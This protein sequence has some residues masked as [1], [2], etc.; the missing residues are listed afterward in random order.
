MLGATGD[1]VLRLPP[2]VDDSANGAVMRWQLPIH[3]PSA[4]ATSSR[5]IGTKLAG[6]LALLAGLLVVFSPCALH[7]TGV[8][9]PL[10]TGLGAKDV[11]S[12][13]GDGAFR[14][15]VVSLGL[16]FVSGFVILYTAFGVA[17][18]FA[19]RFF[20]DTSAL[21]PYL[22]PLRLLAGG[23]VIIMAL[24][25][26]GFFKLPYAIR[27]GVPKRL[28]SSGS[29]SRHVA[30]MLAGANVSAGCL[31]CVGGTL[32]A[33]LLLYAGAS[34]SPLV[35]GATLFLFSAGIS[36]P[37]LITSVALDRAARHFAKAKRFLKYSTTVQASLMLIVGLLIISGNEA[38]FEQLVPSALQSR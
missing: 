35:G 2:L 36:V 10:V 13:A 20:S 19:G 24:Q 6:T 30:A 3:D 26:L 4:G 37:F 18:G 23:F 12:R 9:L 29:R 5:G 8:F 33:S 22:V 16:A 34:G 7:M 25:A 21:R 27:L 32:L 1:L 28:A 31:A 15:R 17:A 38:I 11:A 14:V